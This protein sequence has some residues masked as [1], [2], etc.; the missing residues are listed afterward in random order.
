[1]LKKLG[2]AVLAVL[3]LV[4][5]MA[6]A[7]MAFGKTVV[8]CSPFNGKLINEAGEPQAGISITRDWE[9]GWNSK[10]GTDQ[11]VTAADGTFSFPEVTGSS[12]SVGL[13]PHEPVIN[14]KINADG[15]NGQVRLFSVNKHTYDADGELFGTNLK[16]PG[17]NLVCRIDKE[18]SGDGP[19]WG[20][21]VAAE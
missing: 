12:W 10:T 11:T 2:T 6:E 9:W 16:G 14:Q 13:L 21:C 15:P 17:I 5:V 4:F 19:F 20:T 1:M 3:A 18:P 8:L 7:P